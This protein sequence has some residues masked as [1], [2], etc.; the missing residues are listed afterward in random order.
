MNIIE[1]RNVWKIYKIGKENFPALKDASLKIK[2]NEFVCI[3][4][5]SGSGKSTLLYLIGCLDKP[6]KGDV[7]VFGKNTK[8]LSEKELAEIRNKRIGFVFQTYYLFPNLTV[9]E[10]VEIPM[11]L[12]GRK[13]RKR[14]LELLEKV[15]L[16]G[17]ENKKP[18]ELSGGEQQR[19]CIARALANDPDLILAD[20]PTANLDIESAKNVLEI[21]RNLWKEGKTI[22]IVTHDL[23]IAEYAERIVVL[24]DGRILND[25]A[26]LEEAVELLKK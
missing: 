17:K 21:L 7:Y 19:V 4:G 26:T 10:N 8:K 13:N 5:P 24:K 25:N 16:K 22:V 9:L 12:G 1:L 15:G 6:S 18:N 2:E 20:E 11:I 23:R 14:A 3:M